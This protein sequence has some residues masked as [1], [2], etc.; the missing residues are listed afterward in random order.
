MSSFFIHCKSLFSVS[1]A[2]AIYLDDPVVLRLPGVRVLMRE[3]DA[4][5]EAAMSEEANDGEQA[6]G[7]Y[8]Q[9]SKIIPASLFPKSLR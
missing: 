2:T 8:L 7:I 9:E 4:T 3:D 6:D 5:V 1:S